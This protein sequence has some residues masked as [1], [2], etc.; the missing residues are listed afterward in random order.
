MERDL[1]YRLA[2][3]DNALHELQARGTKFF[4]ETLRLGRVLD[5]LN[6]PRM[7]AEFREKVIADT[8]QEVERRVDDMID[9]LVKTELA[10]WQAVT[11]HVERRRAHHADRIVGDVGGSF[12]YDRERLL[13]TIGKTAADTVATYDPSAEAAR[14]A[15]DVQTSV[16]SAALL[17]VGALGLGAAIA[18]LAT[19][20]AAD[21]TGLL[22][23]GTLAALGLFVLPHRRQKAKAELEEKIGDLR[24]RLMAGLTAQF[25]REMERSLE[26]LRGAIAPYTRFVRS[27]SEHLAGGRD[28][29]AELD[30][31]LVGFE[32]RLAQL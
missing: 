11:R 6:K 30:E 25:E 1:Q 9:W 16:A 15:D 5:L 28:R 31:R 4:D 32:R 17:E 22:A 21:V 3:I 26:R 7:E 29:L 12:D 13:A 18:T 24:R 20:A 14:M 27:E 10:Q 8:P 19:T 23:A 2:D